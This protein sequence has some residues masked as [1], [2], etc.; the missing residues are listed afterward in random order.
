MRTIVTLCAAALLTAIE[1]PLTTAATVNA[2][3]AA[4]RDW[5][6][7]ASASAMPARLATLAKTNKSSAATRFGSSS[8]AGA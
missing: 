4:P 3:S 1:E 5:F 6:A 7:L 8:P 2:V